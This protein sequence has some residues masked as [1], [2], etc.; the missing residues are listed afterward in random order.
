M[1]FLSEDI[2]QDH[3]PILHVHV[4]IKKYYPDVKSLTKL[5]YELCSKT[6]FFFKYMKDFE[7]DQLLV[8]LMHE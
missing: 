2:N 4:I 3:E 8:V 1:G 6:F 5:Y 7:N